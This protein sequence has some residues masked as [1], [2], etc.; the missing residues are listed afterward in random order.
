MTGSVSGNGGPAVAPTDL[1]D[2]G[3][4]WSDGLA[5]SLWTLVP[6]NATRPEPAESG[7]ALARLH[8]V[9]GFPGELPLLAP[10]RDLEETCRGPREFDLAVLDPSP[11][12]GRRWRGCLPGLCSP[13]CWATAS[14]PWPGYSP[15]PPG[16]SGWKAIPRRVAAAASRRSPVHR[17]VSAVSLVAAR[18]CAST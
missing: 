13:A 10:V 15:A 2:A 17:A 1:A 12:E 6:T 4:H 5:V 16:G 14:S 7:R 8:L 9:A 18:S 11:E 3:P